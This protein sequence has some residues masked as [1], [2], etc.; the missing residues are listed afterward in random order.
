MGCCVRV[1]PGFSISFLACGCKAAEAYGLRFQ[2]SE[3]LQPK[4]L[5]G[6]VGFRLDV[7]DSGL[8]FRG[9]IYESTRHDETPKLHTLR[10]E[11]PS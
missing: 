1:L 10:P 4:E 7:A 6:V 8:R 9:P 5:W 11:I 2:S 3:S